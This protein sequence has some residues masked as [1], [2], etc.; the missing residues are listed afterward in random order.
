[1]TICA[2][3]GFFDMP[4]KEAAKAA[5]ADFFEYAA[6]G[7]AQINDFTTEEIF[8]G[9]PRK[10]LKAGDRARGGGTLFQ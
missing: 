7:A 6:A 9:M 8:Y 3:A 10:R 2:V 5:R 4:G 1:M